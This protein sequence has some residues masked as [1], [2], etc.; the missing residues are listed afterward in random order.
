M[1]VAQILVDPLYGALKDYVLNHTGL[2]YYADKDED[3]AMRLSRRIVAR[4]VSDCKSYLGLLTELRFGRQEMDQL[5]GELTI[6]ETY[7]FRHRE[8]F[9]LLRSTIIPDLLVRN[10][11]TRSLRIWSAG[12][13]TGAEPYSIGLLLQLEFRTQL[14]GWNVSIVATDLNLDFLE[15]AR[16]ARFA[17]WALRETPEAIRLRCFTREGHTW[18]LRPDFTRGVSFRYHN[19]AGQSDLLEGPGSFDLILCRN[20]IIYFSRE[21][22]MSTLRLLQRHMSPRGWL[23]VGYAEPNME[24]FKAFEP[25]TTA[26][27]TAYR[28]PGPRP[29]NPWPAR[30]FPDAPVPVRSPSLQRVVIEANTLPRAIQE[31]MPTVDDVR[32]LADTGHWDAASRLTEKLIQT[33]SL[34]PGSHFIS[35]LIHEHLGA[36]DKAM[37][38]LRRAIYLDRRFALAHYHLGTSLTNVRQ[39]ESAS[40]SFRNALEILTTMA[41]D[42]PLPHGDSIT[43]GELR[44]L[45]NMHLE[46]SQ[47]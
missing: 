28:N 16:T 15:R 24:M 14:A 26:D 34:N 9:D 17:E 18:Q 33:D 29:E 38:A 23:L 8:H 19:L 21:Q 47:R 4:T 2:S 30:S 35:A 6:G 7:F 5:V 3:F 22:A 44:T 25:V 13:A 31:T 1:N 37:V 32:V 43:A 27:A 10:R 45:T 42:E 41:D 12:C 36:N 39:L 20:V 11:D 46:M 40:R